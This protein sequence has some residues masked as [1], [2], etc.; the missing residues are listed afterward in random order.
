[1]LFIIIL[2]VNTTVMIIWLLP[3]PFLLLLT[4]HPHSD[5]PW[6]F[7]SS[8]DNVWKGKILWVACAGWSGPGIMGLWCKSSGITLFSENLAHG[9][10]SSV[11]QGCQVGNMLHFLAVFPNWGFPSLELTTNILILSN[12][13]LGILL[14]K[15]CLRAFWNVL[16][17][18]RLPAVDLPSGLNS[19][20]TKF[21]NKSPIT[22]LGRI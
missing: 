17:F 18:Q 10:A 1:M 12:Y 13:A 5:F 6:F 21:T 20:L 8:C 22:L 11:L 7:D 3:K 16:Y 2:Q 15:F 14:W 4:R 19:F 9:G